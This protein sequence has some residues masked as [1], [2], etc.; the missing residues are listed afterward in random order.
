MNRTARMTRLALLIAAGGALHW[1]EAMF[2]VPVAVPGAKLGLANVVTLYAVIMWGLSDG[3]YVAVGRALFGS[4]LG[5]TFGTP[6]FAMSLSGGLV[7]ACVMA[8][9]YFVAGAGAVGASVAGAVSHNL[10][11][12]GVFA[13]I[14]RYAGVFV[15]SPYLILLAIPAGILTG[16]AASYLAARGEGIISSER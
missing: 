5:G 12:L 15:Y 10:T 7:A 16:L 14:T 13:L 1:I 4:L 6:A 2:A 3:L 11:Q 8:A 9:F